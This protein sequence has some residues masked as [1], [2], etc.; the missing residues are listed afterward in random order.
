MSECFFDCFLLLILF[1]Y[2]VFGEKKSFWLKELI[3]RAFDVSIFMTESYFSLSY[4]YFS[5]ERMNYSSKLHSSESY[6]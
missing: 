2:S 3:K 6:F 1:N 5:L 4:V